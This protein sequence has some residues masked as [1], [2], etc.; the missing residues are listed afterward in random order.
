MIQIGLAVGT[1]VRN[2]TLLI[3]MSFFGSGRLNKPTRLPPYRLTATTR[4]MATRIPRRATLHSRVPRNSSMHPLLLLAR[5]FG[6][7]HWKI[8]PPSVPQD[9]HRDAFPGLELFD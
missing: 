5:R 6:Q 1:S 4:T 9:R 2:S 3:S 7:N 8:D